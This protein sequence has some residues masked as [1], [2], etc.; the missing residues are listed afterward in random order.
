MSHP[1]HLFEGLVEHAFHDNDF[2]ATKDWTVA[3]TRNSSHKLSRIV[4]LSPN[5][6]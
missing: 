3:R 2:S 6:V 5:S 1:L 4:I